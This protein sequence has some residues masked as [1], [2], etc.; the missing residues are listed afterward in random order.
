MFPVPFSA[1]I[2]CACDAPCVVTAM[3]NRPVPFSRLKPAAALRKGSIA[4]PDRLKS[5]ASDGV[6][7]LPLIVSL[8]VPAP[9]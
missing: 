6:A 1:C 7:W 5:A 8:P 9:P 4:R 3:L 2:I